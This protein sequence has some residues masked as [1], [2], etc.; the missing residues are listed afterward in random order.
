LR[1]LTCEQ[2]AANSLK[3][4]TQAQKKAPPQGRRSVGCE[5]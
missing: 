4:A 5:K 3:L 2:R 1:E